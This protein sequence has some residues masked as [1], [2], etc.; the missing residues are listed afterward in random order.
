MPSING[1]VI[2]TSKS[3]ITTQN[4]DPLRNEVT[5]SQTHVW[6]TFLHNVVW[7]LGFESTD[8]EAQKDGQNFA[9]C[10]PKVTELVR[11]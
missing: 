11:G 8:I 9:L 5:R 10:V 4:Y 7:L 3:K 6:N 2:S 1:A